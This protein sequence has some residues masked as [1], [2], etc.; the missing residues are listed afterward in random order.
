MLRGEVPNLDDLPCAMV[1]RDN[2]THFGAAV[3]VLDA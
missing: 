1:E 2:V 3:H